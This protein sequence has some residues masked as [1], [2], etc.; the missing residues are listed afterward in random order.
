MF[1]YGILGSTM[2]YYIGK[3]RICIVEGKPCREEKHIAHPQSQEHR[4]TSE[5]VAWQA[6]ARHHENT[7]RKGT[8]EIGIL[9]PISVLRFWISDGL[10]QAES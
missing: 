6:K 2:I 8:E 3:G 4:G 9:R 10:T 7:H 5:A 1:D